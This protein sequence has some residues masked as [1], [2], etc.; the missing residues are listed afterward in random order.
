MKGIQELECIGQEL[1]CRN[2][3]QRLTET[4]YAGTKQPVMI[5]E[6]EP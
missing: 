4:N 5:E 2:S 3:K 6:N 1:D